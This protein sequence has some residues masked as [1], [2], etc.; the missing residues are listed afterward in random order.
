MSVEPHLHCASC[1]AVIETT[2]KCR[3]G[4]T[5]DR[6]LHVVG[7]A[8]LMPGPDGIVVTKQPVALCDACFERIEAAGK[9]SRIV[10]PGRGRAL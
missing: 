10:V 2:I 8:T 3:D 6:E 7:K 1:Q 5:K 9:P 4:K